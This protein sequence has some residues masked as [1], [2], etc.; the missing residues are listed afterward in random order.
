MSSPGG[1]LIM[2]DNQESKGKTRRTW[3]E[4][5]M[6]VW[7]RLERLSKKQ[8]RSISWM[9]QAVLRDMLGLPPERG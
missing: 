6:E 9:I 7:K 3:V 4:L 5:D 1:G 2:R 8:E